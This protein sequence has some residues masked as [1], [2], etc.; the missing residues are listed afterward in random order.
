VRNPVVLNVAVVPLRELP[1]ID[2]RAR[3]RTG[4]D[5][6][7]GGA[8]AARRDQDAPARRPRV[9]LEEI[10]AEDVVVHITTTPLRPSDAPALVDALVPHAAHA[11]VGEESPRTAADWPYSSM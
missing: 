8:R 4:N 11:S 10:D 1:R 3:L 7:G 5:A 2:V 6:A 9:H